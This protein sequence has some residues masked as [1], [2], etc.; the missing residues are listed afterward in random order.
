MSRADM[1]LPLTQKMLPGLGGPIGRRWMG[2]RPLTP[3]SLP[4][5]GA[6]PG[7][8][9]VLLAY[10]HGQLG[11]TMGP[12]TGRIVAALARG[13]DPGIDMAPYRPDRF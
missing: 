10:G 7:A 1:L 5:L 2:N 8:P 12:A 13:D 11:L 9:N 6:A 4:V 3:D